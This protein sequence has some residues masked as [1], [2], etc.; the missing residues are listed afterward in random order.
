[1]NGVS[2]LLAEMV[3]VGP[4]LAVRPDHVT[5]IEA[6][7]T[8]PYLTICFVGGDCCRLDRPTSELV[9]RE[10]ARA[11]GGEGD[12]SDPFGLLRNALPPTV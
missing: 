5:R 1:M 4:A 3:V 8:P 11:A 2:E 12:A 7:A 10:M 6:G 9:R